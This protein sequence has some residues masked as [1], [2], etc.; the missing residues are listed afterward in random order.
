M[1]QPSTINAARG[2]GI[3]KRP[4][5]RIVEAKTKLS[6]IA[7]T[8]GM[9]N[10]LATFKVKKIAKMKSPVRAIDRTLNGSSSVASSPTSG[11]GLFSGL[12]YSSNSLRACCS[13]RSEEH[14]SE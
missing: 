3:H 11:C 2:G 4:K 9:K 7:S 1:K 12:E 14:T 13:A 8:T 6:K 10:E 5:V